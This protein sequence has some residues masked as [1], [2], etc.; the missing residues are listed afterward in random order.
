[1]CEGEIYSD[2]DAEDDSLKNI[3]CDFCLKWY[4]LRCTEF[5]NLNYKEA[6]IREFMCYACK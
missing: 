5:A 3:G 1:M 6:M 2:G 4:H